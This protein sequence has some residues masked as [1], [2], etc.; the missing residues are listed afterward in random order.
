M[1]SNGSFAAISALMCNLF[2]SVLDLSIPHQ[3]YFLEWYSFFRRR[4]KIEDYA[5]ILIA[6]RSGEILGSVI[7]TKDDSK[8]NLITG[9]RVGSLGAL[10]VKE[11]ARGK[12]V[13]DSLWLPRPLRC[14]RMPV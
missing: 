3:T 6:Q 9:D 12:M 7:V 1:L 14:T 13:L 5:S 10:G 8:W 11:S 2:P 4:I